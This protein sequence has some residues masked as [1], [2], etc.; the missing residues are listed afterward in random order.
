MIKRVLDKIRREPNINELKKQGM[1][2]GENFSYGSNCFFDPAHCFLISIGN[3]VTFSTHIHIVAHD[4][5]TIKKIGYAKVGRVDIGDNVFVGANTTILPGVEIGADT[6]IGA[7][8]VVTKNCK[9]QSVYAGVPAKKICSLDEYLKKV[10]D[11]DENMKFGED[12]TIRGN[13]TDEKKMEMKRKLK[14]KRFGL[15]K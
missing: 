9:K 6:I 12:Y 1:E 8:S 10:Q 11:V 14:E 2:V 4:A 3:N 5:S 13:I 7:G 15:V